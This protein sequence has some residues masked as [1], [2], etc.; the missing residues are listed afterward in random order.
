MKPSPPASLV[1][2]GE[3]D[4]VRL[5]GLE[6]AAAGL[7][8]VARRAVSRGE[9]EGDRLR[10][11][12]EDGGTARE[13]WVEPGEPPR[14]GAR[15][16]CDC[17]AAIANLTAGDGAPYALGCAH[18]AALLTAWV[19][20]PSDFT[21]PLAP[22]T[23]AARVPTSA[24]APA[25]DRPP[26][27]PTEQLTQPRLLR[28]PGRARS[29]ITLAAELE[30]LPAADLSALARR[31]LNAD[32]RDAEARAAL[33]TALRS[34]AVLDP[35]LARLDGGPRALLAKVLL[36]GGAV[37][38][39]DLDGIAARSGRPA[40]ALHAEMAA[41]VRHGL[42]FAASA[43]SAAPPA[44][45]GPAVARSWRQI[46]GWRVPSDLRPLLPATLPIPPAP[47][48]ADGAPLLP[49]GVGAHAMRPMRVV[50]GNPR[51]LLLALALLPRAPGPL[52]PF[53]AASA[54]PPREIVPAASRAARR[55][56][57]P[58]VPG[59]LA[60][61]ALAALARGLGVAPELAQL[62]RRLLLWSREAGAGLALH[63]L[64]RL[65]ALELPLALREAFA[66]WRHAELPAELADLDTSRGPVRAGYD[67]AHAALRPASL[68]AEVAGARDFTLRLLAAAGEGVW[69]RADDLLE[70]VW[71]TAPLF[72]RGR[73]SAY[74]TPA[75]WLRTA[76]DPRPLRPTVRA[77]WE[78]GEGCY[79][80]ALLE[81]PPHWLG[82]LDLAYAP[83]G[84]LFAMR[85]T[86]L[87]ANLL[88][89]HATP[90]DEGFHH[91]G[92]RGDGGEKERRV[93]AG[94][95]QLAQQDEGVGVPAA[96]GAWGMPVVQGR[97][98]TLAVHPLAA[99]A[100]LLDAIEMWARPEAVAGGRLVYRLAADRAC[101][102]LDAGAAPDVLLARLAAL[103]TRHGTHVAPGARAR[104]EAWRAAYGASRIE[105]GW[106]LIEARDAA[107]L[108]EALA[109]APQIA[110]RCRQ[111]A[112]AVALVPDDDAPA[113]RAA[114]AR[115][116]FQ[117]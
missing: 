8:L 44:D 42:V 99:G 73:Q 102:A 98:G 18:V 19:R 115:R 47:T 88:D 111:I 22:I 113:L 89:L 93:I 34:P 62:A 85:L 107:V 79:L 63:D 100:E 30:R 112:P 81:G 78:A 31:V 52:N 75:W 86:P 11:V 23:G 67:A 53:A 77:E 87:G 28:P 80:M 114:L 49:A 55:A 3:A 41:L 101:A 54:S 69:Y 20:V 59:D 72:L 36:L 60:P 4:V 106:T 70:L 74:A 33:E 15:W 116:G 94:G 46:S 29:A 38:A 5:C 25:A 7:E 56:P 17:P 57:F 103:D 40:S 65:P 27:T 108:A 9:R 91:K 2:L 58:L 109:A 45:A 6:A 95:S 82:A 104:L 71:S 16:H 61:S 26:Q 105:A 117:V 96:W 21:T 39:A 14:E 64:T 48:R 97:E 32:L 51:A 76:D 92:N 66:V 90:G 24:P 68:A 13:V 10:A 83:D 35:L 37:T 84:R 110:A 43:A 1:R 50:R 12:V